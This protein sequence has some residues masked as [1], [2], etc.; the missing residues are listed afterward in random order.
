[1]PYCVFRAAPLLLVGR[2]SDEK[3]HMRTTDNLAPT[4]PR[5]VTKEYF[6]SI[7]VAVDCIAG[8]WKPAILFHLKDGPLRF[9]ELTRL[10]PRASKKVLGEQL[11]QLA[12]DGL[13]RRVILDREVPTGV[14]YG[15]TEAARELTSV[16]QVL[17][18][19]GVQHARRN[20]IDLTLD[21]MPGG[22][23]P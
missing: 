17:H 9:T 11:R 8:K 6:C 20:N 14:E 3:N 12:G 16:L 10:I 21:A 13:V 2:Q 15:L 18:I 22:E 5:R 23:Q 1:M 7:E 19:W 4:G